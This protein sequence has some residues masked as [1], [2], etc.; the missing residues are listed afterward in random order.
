M[1]ADSYGNSSSVHSSFLVCGNCISLGQLLLA[2]IVPYTSF[3]YHMLDGWHETSRPLF[4]LQ[5]ST[6]MLKLGQTMGPVSQTRKM[7]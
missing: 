7:Y 1:V 2:H 5:I 6:V 4:E 3:V